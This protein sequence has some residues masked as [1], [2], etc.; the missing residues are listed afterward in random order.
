MMLMMIETKYIENKW[1]LV[2]TYGFHVE[3]RRAQAYINQQ[4]MFKKNM[5]TLN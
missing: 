1:K 2:S 4:V 3:K 5:K